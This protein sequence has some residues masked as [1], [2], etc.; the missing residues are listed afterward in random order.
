MMTPRFGPIRTPAPKTPDQMSLIEKRA[1]LINLRLLSL[2]RG[3]MV[4][5]SEEKWPTVKNVHMFKEEQADLL[6]NSILQAPTTLPA[7]SVFKLSLQD[8]EME[9]G[10]MSSPEIHHPIV[11]QGS[12]M[13]RL[14]LT[15]LAFLTTAVYG[16]K[17]V[18]WTGQATNRGEV[19]SQQDDTGSTI[20]PIPVA[21]FPFSVTHPKSPSSFFMFSLL[22]TEIRLDIWEL[23]L[24][25]PRFVEVQYCSDFYEPTFVNLPCNPLSLVC[26]ESAKVVVKGRLNPNGETASKLRLFPSHGHYSYPDLTFSQK[27]KAIFQSGERSKPWPRPEISFI[28][29]RDTIFI[30]SL[31]GLKL[32]SIMYYMPKGRLLLD[33]RQVQHLALPLDATSLAASQ[34]FEPFLYRMPALKSLTFMVGSSEKPWMTGGSIELRPLH[35]WFADG[36][37]K[38]IDFSGKREALVRNSQVQSWLLNPDFESVTGHALG[39]VSGV[40]AGW[41]DLMISVRVAAWKRK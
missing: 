33:M 40:H 31:D 10:V 39:V 21:S 32:N 13:L 22:P 2:E 23:A 1:Q 8:T 5:K 41:R 14:L 20:K 16:Q 25:H 19:I 27:Q 36:R 7:T 24:F 26:R 35:Q 11:A 6:A 34:Q 12:T 15:A 9:S 30:R 17:R 18:T 3:R 37:N 38:W 29:S 28:P 4:L